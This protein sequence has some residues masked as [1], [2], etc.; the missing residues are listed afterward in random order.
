MVLGCTPSPL[1]LSHNLRLSHGSTSTL[2]PRPPFDSD[3]NPIRFC[4]GFYRADQSQPLAAAAAAAAAA[5]SPRRTVTIFGRRTSGPRGGRTE[6]P[7]GGSSRTWRCGTITPPL[8]SHSLHL[9][10]GQNNSQQSPKVNTADALCRYSHDP[11]R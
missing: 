9:Q 6:G 7:Q 1:S 2:R 11:S 4:V 5:V 10:E 8:Q 3:V